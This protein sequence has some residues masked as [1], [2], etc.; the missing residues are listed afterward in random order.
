MTE[1]LLSG[2]GLKVALL[3]ATSKATLVVI[4][5]DVLM[6]I[7][8]IFHFAVTF[9]TLELSLRVLVANVILE[10]FPIKKKKELC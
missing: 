5:L 4:P 3:R 1:Q 6:Q 9:G 7:V 8:V 2:G 10:F